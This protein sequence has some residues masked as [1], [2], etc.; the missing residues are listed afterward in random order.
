MFETYL[1]LFKRLKL[2]CCRPVCKGRPC[3]QGS[4]ECQQFCCTPWHVL[5]YPRTSSRRPQTAFWG[6]S[7][8]SSLLLC[9]HVRGTCKQRHRRSAGWGTLTRYVRATVCGG[10]GGGGWAPT[11]GGFVTQGGGGDCWECAVD[12]VGILLGLCWDCAGVV[13]GLCW[14]CPGLCWSVCAASACVW[15]QGSHPCMR[16]R[17]KLTTCRPL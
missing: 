13:L 5:T 9:W 3:W 11:P 2:V 15:G 8:C 14:G 1:T 10:V 12:C 6:P 17:H 16:R 4:W 7:I